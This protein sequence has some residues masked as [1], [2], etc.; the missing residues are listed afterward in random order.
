MLGILM[1][2]P[3]AGTALPAGPKIAAWSEAQETSATLTL[4]IN[5]P[6]GAQI[7]DTL[8]LI[9][10]LG[11]TS[12][13]GIATGGAP[14][15]TNVSTTGANPI[16]RIW[17]KVYAAGDPTTFT[18]TFQNPTSVTLDKTLMMLRVT[19]GGFVST[20]APSTSTSP[21]NIPSRTLTVAPTLYIGVMRRSGGSGGTWTPPTGF[22]FYAETSDFIKSITIFERT[23]DATGATGILS[24]AST[25]GQVWG[26]GIA[27]S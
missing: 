25:V 21:V 27:L 9:A 6:V 2:R 12:I 26:A 22:D 23:Y 17:R 7:G 13:A 20:G 14:G 10:G 1:P 19:G 4:S 24:F 8:I 5:V 3:L 11:T 18:V 15:W 16:S